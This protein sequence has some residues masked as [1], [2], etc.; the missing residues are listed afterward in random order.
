M[1]TACTFYI[2][3]NSLTEEDLNQEFYVEGEAIRDTIEGE[4]SKFWS[5]YVEVAIPFQR[6]NRNRELEE[7]KI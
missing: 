2:D 4:E 7:K 3:S 6:I 1:S 5:E